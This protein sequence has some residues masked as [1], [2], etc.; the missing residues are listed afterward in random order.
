[1]KSQYA[2]RY[3]T[4]QKAEWTNEVKALKR[5]NGHKNIVK[6]LDQSRISKLEIKET[7]EHVCV[8]NFIAM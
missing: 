8:T 4:R 2:E 5:L 7:T 3:G 1:M 6:M